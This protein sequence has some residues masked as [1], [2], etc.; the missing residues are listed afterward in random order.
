ME[1]ELK[2][3][4]AGGEATRETKPDET[5]GDGR[6]RLYKRKGGS[7]AWGVGT[8]RES[9]QIIR[10]GTTSFEEEC[11]QGTEWRGKQ[12][13]VASLAGGRGDHKGQL[14]VILF[15]LLVLYCVVTN[16]SRKKG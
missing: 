7:R 10:E 2:T 5:M 4:V 15:L 14:H 6:G 12:H 16:I 11:E 3:K 8:R 1:T 13:I 9:C